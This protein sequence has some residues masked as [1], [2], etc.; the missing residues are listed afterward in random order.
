VRDS[1]AQHRASDEDWTLIDR[2]RSRSSGSRAARVWKRMLRDLR[3]CCFRRAISAATMSSISSSTGCSSIGVRI[4]PQGARERR[5]RVGAMVERGVARSPA[6]WRATASARARKRRGIVGGDG[7]SRDARRSDPGRRRRST[8]LRAVVLLSLCLGAQQMTTR[9]SGRRRFVS[10]KHPPQLRVMNTA[11]TSSAESARCSSVDGGAAGWPRPW[12]PARGS[13][14]WRPL[15]V[16]FGP[17][18]MSA[19]R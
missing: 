6:G 8:P 5:L 7:R 11:G 14:C 10:G 17:T 18:R 15:V 12:P 4:A 16:L 1:P 19:R 9:S 3:C 13:P 2:D